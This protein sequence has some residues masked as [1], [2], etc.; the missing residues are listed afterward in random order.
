M[1]ALNTAG[2]LV[3]TDLDGT[4]LDHDTYSWA[5]AYKTLQRLKQLDIP[6]VINTSKTADEV[7][8]LQQDMGINSPFIVENG[9]AVYW[10]QGYDLIHAPGEVLAPGYCGKVLGQKRAQLVA[11]LQTIRQE[12]G[13]KFEGF[14]DWT[15]EQV[16]GHTGLS[17]SSAK[18]AQAR[19]YSEPILWR[20]TADELNA[21]QQVL[22]D[23]GMNLL[24]GG[25][26]YH[27]L[28]KCD[29][30]SAM[31][32]LSQ[33]L[34]PLWGKPPVIVALGDS[35]NDLDMLKLAHWPVLVKSPKHPFPLVPQSAA[36]IYYTDAYGPEGWKEA[37]EH[38]LKL[39]DGSLLE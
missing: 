35:G 33:Q 19:G 38:H 18:R 6:V 10:R 11:Q 16:M 14:N 23:R 31:T 1:I 17:P 24:K 21:F 7:I 8:S 13:W 4:L 2:L 22:T 20:D 29:K 39:V 30:G 12:F 32:W 5:A 37:M 15:I 36:D 27:V 9:S 28:G 34:E 26:F 25:R 3:V